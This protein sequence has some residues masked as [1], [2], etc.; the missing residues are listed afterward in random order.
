MIYLY[1]AK[2]QITDIDLNKTNYKYVLE[3][4]P[5]LIDTF[6]REDKDTGMKEYI[7]TAIIIEKI[8][9]NN[10]RCV[11]CSSIDASIMAENNNIIEVKEFTPFK[12]KVK[13]NYKMDILNKQYSL[14]VLDVNINR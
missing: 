13:K 11:F 8:Y 6:I 9:P 1:I 7:E 3:E 14:T 12:L 4:Q 5:L 2:I 10:I